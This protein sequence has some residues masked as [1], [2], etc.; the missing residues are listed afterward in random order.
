MIFKIPVSQVF[1]PPYRTIVISELGC[2]KIKVPVTVNIRC[3]Y[4]GNPCG[5]F[6][7][8]VFN[9]LLFSVVL[10]YYNRT[11]FIVGRIDSYDISNFDF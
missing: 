6:K 3:P 11:D 4:I 8:N 10:K 2:G 7:D 9:E 1:D 5:F